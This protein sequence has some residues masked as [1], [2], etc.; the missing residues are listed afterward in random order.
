MLL[1]PHPE[2]FRYRNLVNASVCALEPEIWEFIPDQKPLNFEKDLVIAALRA[3]RTVLAY[4]T[5]EYIRDMG[6]PDRWQGVGKDLELGLPAARSLVRKQKAI[7]LDRDGVLNVYKGLITKPED[8]VLE[9]GAIEAVKLINRSTYLAIVITNQPQIAKGLCSIEQLNEIHKQLDTHLGD[10]A[11]KLDDIFFCPHHPES[12]FPG[13]VRELKIVCKCRKPNPGMLLD[14][15]AQFNIDLSQ[16]YLIGDMTQDIVAGAACGAK[17]V[18]VNTGLRGEDGK[19]KC[20]PDL[21]APNV[22]AAV[23][24]AL[25]DGI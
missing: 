9:D 21:R 13:E 5:S 15:A 7:F 25:A 2:N 22:L 17:T 6:T 20:T 18:L 11:A 24:T 12:G 8:L 19:Y 14:A 10:N 4:N 3:G 1:R 16:S 23:H